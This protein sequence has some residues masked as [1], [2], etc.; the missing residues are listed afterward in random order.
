LDAT[1]YGEFRVIVNEWIIV[2][3]YQDGMLGIG[4]GEG[5]CNEEVVTVDEGE[6]DV[7]RHPIELPVVHQ[8]EILPSVCV[9][10]AYQA[11]THRRR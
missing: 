8:S 7:E 3:D 10:C 9:G 5:I 6:Q 4:N 1:L 11:P 2:V